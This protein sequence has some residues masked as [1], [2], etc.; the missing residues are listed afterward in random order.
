MSIVITFLQAATREGKQLER[1]VMEALDK[2]SR[3]G[4]TVVTRAE[5][6]LGDTEE[7]EGVASRDQDLHTPRYCTVLY[8]TVLYC[9]VAS[10]DQHLHTPSLSDQPRAQETE[11]TEAGILATEP[12]LI[13]NSSI[14][15]SQFSLY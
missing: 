7:E 2:C 9:T 1:V 3:S 12:A 4:D 8:C 11:D 10:R 14:S 6:H 5:H 13:E 15:V